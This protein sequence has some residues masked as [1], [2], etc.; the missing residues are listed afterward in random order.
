MV[1]E[2]LKQVITDFKPYHVSK[3]MTYEDGLLLLVAQRFYEQTGDDFYLDFL[4]RYMDAHIDEK[5]HIVNYSV[6]EYNIDNILAGNALFFMWNQTKDPRYINTL[7]QLRSQLLTHPRTQA[8]NFWHKLR[9]PNQVWLDGVYMGQV[10]YLNYG[11]MFEEEGIASDVIHQVE[12]VRRLLWDEKKKLYLHAYDE[13]KQMQWAD[14]STG[15]SPNVWSR[16]VGWLAMAL[17]EVR[18]LFAAPASIP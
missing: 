16:S 12:N 4:H 6:E 2:F 11:L 17:A 15:R 13:S 8:G 10:F 7:S 1:E 18:A 3:G 14:P 9:Y 5:G